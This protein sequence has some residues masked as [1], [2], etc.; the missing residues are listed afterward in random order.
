MTLLSDRDILAAVDAGRIRL[1]PF[2]PALVQPSSVDVRLGEWLRVFDPHPG[3]D[4]RQP[5]PEGLTAPVKAEGYTLYPGEFVL[6]S[7]AEHLTL[8]DD[9]ASRLE[10]KSSRG[11]LGLAAHV[12]AGFIDPGF[13]GEITLELSNVGP[14]P[15]TLGAGMKIGQLVFE[16]M[17]SPV[18]RPY[19]SSGLQSKYQGQRGPTPARSTEEAA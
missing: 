4:L 5:L 16:A 17:S 2:D 19:G 14:Y 18:A 1:D 15:L 7:T 6:G 12:C 10:G 11:R 8:G 3:I 9:I 13:S